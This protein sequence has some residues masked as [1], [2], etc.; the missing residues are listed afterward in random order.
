MTAPADHLDD[1]CAQLE[2]AAARLREGGL[3]PDEAAT[4]VD[5]CAA[6]AADASVELERQTRTGVQTPPAQGELL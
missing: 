3:S 2:A 4:V 6:L 5:R 1:L